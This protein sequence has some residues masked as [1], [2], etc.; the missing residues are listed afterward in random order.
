MKR[1]MYLPL[2]ALLLLTCACENEET[3]ILDNGELPEKVNHVT[4]RFDDDDKQVYIAPAESLDKGSLTFIDNGYHLNPVRSARVFT[5]DLGW[6][7]MFDYGGGFLKKL[8]YSNGQYTEV[9]E[10]SIT[11]VMGGNAY[12]RP[13]K[14]N[15]ETILIHNANTY[16]IEDTL[17]NG[18]TKEA[19]L[20]VTRITIPDVVISEILD[21]W[22][23]PLTEWDEEEKAYVFRVD[24]P[25]VLGDK[26]YY[27]VGRKT[28][29]ENISLT[30]MHT[31]VLDYPSLENPQYIR[32]EFANGNTNGYRGGNMHA[33]DGHVYQ[34]NC[35]TDETQDTKLVRLKDGEYDT[36][37]EFNIT[38]ALGEPFSTT[39]WYH[40]KDGICYM[41][42]QLYS[43]TDENNQWAV[44]RIDVIN[45]T[46]VKLNLPM[47]YLF[48]YQNGVTIGDKFYMSICP[49]G[50]D[51][52]SE[53][54]I[55][56]FDINS[57][58]PNSV[59]KGL[60]LDNGNIRIEG[61]F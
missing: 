59:T 49:Q 43:A 61:I 33:I 25:T 52:E 30:G 48:A 21:T 35:S 56:S 38:E 46:V 2:S 4:A 39:N 11:Q 50:G 31:I 10:L 5:D 7:Y 15:D 45:Q 8:R 47:S 1:L 58:N 24:V 29:D 23:I 16:D 51:A 53:P 6:V 42:A 40:A 20:Y 27:G 3:T 22:T 36:S 28:L 37:W 19:I 18:I 57:T 55:Y 60:K 13:Y 41:P 54:Y 14:I 9:R 34:A 12:V 17:G 26:I 44:L 32:S